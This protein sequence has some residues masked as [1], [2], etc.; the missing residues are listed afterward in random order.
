MKKPREI[1]EAQSQKAF[2]HN[3]LIQ[4]TDKRLSLT[5]IKTILYIISK[6][7]PNDK[8]NEEYTF[9]IKEFCQACNYGIDGGG[10]YDYV[11]DVLK[12]LRKKDIVIHPTENTTLITGWFAEAELIK[13]RNEVIISFANKVKPYLFNLT[14]NFTDIWLEC[15]LPMKSLY[16]VLLFMYL[17]SVKY[18]GFKHTLELDELRR[19]MGCQGKYE[20][21]SD[22]RKYIIE[23]ALK[24]INTFTDL[25][26]SYKFGKS[27]RKVV[28]VE[29]DVSETAFDYHK[30]LF[31]RSMALGQR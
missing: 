25:D 21:S 28:N 5:E 24:D 12:E 29:F 1:I 13:D 30:R 3:V 2:I 15:V 14:K 26:V 4:H 11:R 22:I 10:R 9:S 18:K 16:G 8:P 7:K 17:S 19:L 27:G 6:I 20:Q 23:P 31:N